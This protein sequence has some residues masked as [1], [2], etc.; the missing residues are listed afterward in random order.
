MGGW[1]G[2]WVGGWTRTGDD[3]GD[4]AVVMYVE[5]G[6]GDE[7]GDGELVDLVVDG[8]DLDGPVWV[9]GWVGERKEGGMVW[10]EWVG[11]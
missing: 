8:V 4:A 9:G 5:D 3:G 6:L 2:G 1:V 11:G 10:R 7:G